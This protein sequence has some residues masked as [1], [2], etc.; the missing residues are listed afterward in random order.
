MSSLPYIASFRLRL[1][2]LLAALLG[3]T[4][5]VQYY[6]NLRSVRSNTQRLAEQEQAIMGGMALGVSAVSSRLYLDDLKKSL[7]Q[8]LLAENTG[9]V[10]NVLVV[11]SDGN[12]R[13]SLDDD[14]EPTTKED[15]SAHFVP[16]TS[17]PLPPLSGVVEF[18]DES[19]HRPAW[20]AVANAAKPGEPAAFYLPVETN[21]GR[22]YV[23]VVL[24]SASN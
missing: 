7:K 1:L 18:V 12:V 20:L 9:R 6:V 11:D 22:W 10:K 23:I 17:V 21:R 8:P 19:Q 5:G 3:L 4:L 14:Y 16:L 2:L 15:G 24:G 13:D